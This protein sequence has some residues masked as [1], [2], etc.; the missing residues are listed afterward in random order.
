MS[1]AQVRK[2]R[3]RE[4]GARKPGR[5][6]KRRASSSSRPGFPASRL[7]APHYNQSMLLAGDVGGTK[8]LLGTLSAGR[9]PP[10][11]RSSVSSP[12]RIS[13]ASTTLVQ[14]FLAETN[15]GRI[16]AVCIGIAGTVNGLRATAGQRAL[17]GADAS[18]LSA[19]FGGC[20][21]AARQRSGGHG[22]CRACARLRTELT[23]LQEAAAS[24]QPVTPP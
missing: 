15:A 8:T 16:E 20:P 1:A 9:R 23:V 14:T 3:A 17:A 18:G 21:V 13:T 19:R 12:R 22:V 6:W 24:P 7:E 2:S 4:L 10:G 5:A 11:P